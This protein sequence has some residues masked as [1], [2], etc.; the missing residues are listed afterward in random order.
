MRGDGGSGWMVFK[1]DQWLVS[2]TKIDWFFSKSWLVGSK[3][4]K[5]PPSPRRQAIVW[6]S[7]HKFEGQSG[8]GPAL[9]PNYREAYGMYACNG[10]LFNHESPRRGVT[11]VTRKIARGVARIKKVRGL[12]LLVPIT[13]WFHFLS[14]VPPLYISAKSIFLFI[15]DMKP[16]KPSTNLRIYESKYDCSWFN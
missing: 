3:S 7:P 12:C 2:C 9:P 1:F 15:F 11:F 8:R 13:V 6:F 16:P 5:S 4:F 14:D 10:I